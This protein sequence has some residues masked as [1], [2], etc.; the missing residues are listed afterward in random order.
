MRIGTAVVGTQLKFEEVV[1]E[2]RAA[3]A[4]GLDSVF[5]PQLDDWD[6]IALAGAAGRE[7]PGIEVATGIVPTYPRHPV[8]MASQAL[9]AA[10]LTGG[11]F[12]L[13]IGPGHA[14]IM[15]DRLGYS[16]DRPVRHVREYLEA[17]R[18]LLRGEEVG[19]RGETLTAAGRTAVPG[20]APPPVLL[21]ALGP[22][23]LRL[24][25]ELADGTITNWMR[26]EAIA[27]QVA[28]AI[29]RAA[30]E[31]GRPA[32]RIVAFTMVALT[33]D[34]DGA[35]AALAERLGFAGDFP[36]YRTVLDRQGLSGVHET[37]IAGDERAVEAAIRR[38][39]SAG[40]TDL[41]L[42][43]MGG[44]E[45]RDRVLRLAASVS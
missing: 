30:A 28:P 27:E 21:S 29:G 35:R 3:A 44:A 34:P 10:A 8:V 18:P 36:S 31:A 23:M 2:V 1:G 14:Q 22:R 17:L 38:Y 7:V 4:A 33:G 6:A 45:E 19:Y 13:G 5:F 20:A 16:Y 9:T 32:P 11:R 15:T 12:T 39:A 37:I 42:S 26:P 41:L 24:A 25:G 43:P 40:A